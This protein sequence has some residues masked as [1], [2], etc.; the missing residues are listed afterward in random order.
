MLLD[1]DR[2]AKHLE[3]GETV[4]WTG[5]PPQGL[6]L[7]RADAVLIPFTFLWLAV[8]VWVVAPDFIFPVED[9]VLILV[10]G[11]LA[12]GRFV[13]DAHFRSTTYY[14]VTD[15]RIL[16]LGGF[17]GKSVE[18]IA[19]PAAKDVVLRLRDAA[20]GTLV[21][22]PEWPFPKLHSTYFQNLEFYG[23]LDAHTAAD[24]IRN[25]GRLPHPAQTSA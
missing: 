18:T 16:I 23:T 4:L 21:F 9:T 14:A 3:P 24:L 1:A 19:F 2:F 10:G 5:R 15:R 12:V 6:L 11:Y 17:R 7:R 25:R 22:G 8:G 20:R 13:A